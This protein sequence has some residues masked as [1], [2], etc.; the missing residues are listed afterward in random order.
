MGGHFT[1]FDELEGRGIAVEADDQDVV[2]AFETSLLERLGG[3]EA[4]GSL[5]A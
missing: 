4:S 2:H 1:G 5:V 3:T